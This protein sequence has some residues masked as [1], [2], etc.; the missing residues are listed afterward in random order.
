MLSRLFARKSR[1]QSKRFEPRRLAH[2]DAL[3]SRLLMDGSLFR[4]I[5]YGS[6]PPANAVV[7]MPVNSNITIYDN[8]AWRSAADL[9][10]AVGQ[11]ITGAPYTLNYAGTTAT[12][13]FAGTSSTAKLTVQQLV[14]N[15]MTLAYSVPGNSSPNRIT[16]STTTPGD[17]YVPA[18]ANGGSPIHLVAAINIS[19]PE[20]ARHVLWKTDS[21]LA[22]SF[23]PQTPDPSFVTVTADTTV[24][25]GGVDNNNDGVLEDSEVTRT[26]NVHL[27]KFPR[28]E[29]QDEANTDNTVVSDSST[30]VNYTVALGA[31]GTATIALSMPE[32]PT[33]TGAGYIHWRLFK[34]VNVQGDAA[35]T[36]TP[37]FTLTVPGDYV[38]YAGFDK[39]LSN[40]LG[41]DEYQHTIT[42]H[43]VSLP[44]LTVTDLSP[45]ADGIPVTATGSTPANG[46]L[47]TDADGNALINIV[48]VANPTSGQ[49]SIAY[50]VLDASTGITLAAGVLPA[51]GVSTPLAGI[52]TGDQVEVNA[53]V[54]VNHNGIL[55][56]G[57]LASARTVL[58][59][60]V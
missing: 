48:G 2:V 9:P 10:D 5:P 35:I 22:S 39:N 8:T 3:E 51:G 27:V 56:S 11:A 24:F 13:S 14:L 18:D 30:N 36:S 45:D 34:G 32:G 53:W 23:T 52:G 54:D 47:V 50:Q 12:L 6:A 46:T 20:A 31:D 1:R 43:A 60:Q 16:V 59:T 4:V 25:A 44:G 37:S 19:G 15:T 7:T 38:L 29:A 17:I 33:G 26:I 49:S 55:D 40:S 28:L 42:I 41:S 58:L 21:G 57:E